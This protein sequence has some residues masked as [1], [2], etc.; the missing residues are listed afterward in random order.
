[1]DEGV[2]SLKWRDHRPT[3]TRTLAALQKKG[4][5]CDATLA[6]DGRFYPVHKLVLG[7]CSEFFQRMFEV[8]EKQ[9]MMV[10][11]ADLCHEDLEA[12]LD[13]M[14]IGEANILQGD[15]SRFMRAAEALKIKGLA[16]PAESSPKRDSGEGKRSLGTRDDSWEPKRRK[17]NTT[18]TNKYNTKVNLDD[19]GD[20][21]RVSFGGRERGGCHSQGAEIVSPAQLAAVELAVD[22]QAD[23][24]ASH[25]DQHTHPTA[26]SREKLH[27][28]QSTVKYEEVNVKEELEEWPGGDGS[29]GGGGN[30]EADE[31]NQIYC[32]FSDPGLAY[33]T[34]HT[35][36]LHSGAPTSPPHHPHHTQTQPAVGWEGGIGSESAVHSQSTPHRMHSQR[37]MGRPTS[38]IWSHY[39]VV[40]N[41]MKTVV[42]CKYCSQKYSHPNA[43][44]MKIH[45]VKC[46]R[47]PGEVRQQF[48]GGVK[49]D[50]EAPEG[51][52]LKVLEPG[53]IAWQTRPSEL[54]V[55]QPVF[56]RVDP[57]SS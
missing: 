39:S 25:P 2:L 19:G 16:E 38:E 5:Y 36:T 20:R 9:Q 18:S 41:A 56:P 26:Q 27:N 55:P 46:E 21:D 48:S 42:F 15:L 28:N 52:T 54:K 31:S 45:I 32:T 47:C 33:L 22:T 35:S 7:T 40:R 12:L 49:P 13:Y 34:G 6:C 1:M 51:S 23:T 53:A 57:S 14:Y 3:F 10:V 24:A 30:G 29:G 11:L 50:L 43:T 17:E 37:R 44:K 4:S 8:G